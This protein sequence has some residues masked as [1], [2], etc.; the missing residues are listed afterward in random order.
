[1]SDA[2]QVAG[3]FA[4]AGA[5]DGLVN[6]AALLVGRRA[7]DEIDLDEWDRMVQR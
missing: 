6:C 7:Y 1:M 5:I 4:D 3:V 2:D